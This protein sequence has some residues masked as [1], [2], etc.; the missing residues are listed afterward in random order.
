MAMFIYVAIHSLYN[1]LLQ[2]WNPSPFHYC[3]RE[4]KL[5][6]KIFSYTACRYSIKYKH[7]IY[8]Y[9]HIPRST[10]I[11][12]LT[13]V[14]QTQLTC[15]KVWTAWWYWRP[16][17]SGSHLC[18]DGCSNERWPGR[19]HVQTTTLHQLLWCW[20]SLVSFVPVPSH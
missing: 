19:L 9:I 17:Q 7:Q 12:Q 3:G 10:N 20:Q 2:V 13:K 15:K 18:V 6:L 14:T 5:L 8:N 16:F 4:K 11:Y 1:F